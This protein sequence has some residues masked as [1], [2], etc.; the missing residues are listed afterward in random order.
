MNGRDS[1]E[2]KEE[3]E[4]VMSE[5]HLGC[6]PGIFGPHISRFTI[7]LPSGVESS[8][9]NGLFKDQE[10]CTDQ[11]ISFD[12]DGDLVLP[13]RR[14]ISRRCFTMKIQHNITSSIPS[15]GLQVW[16]AELVLSDF[17][18]HK[19]CTSMEFHGI[20]SLE[21]GAGTGLAGMLLA[22]AARTVFL[23]DHGDKI[24]ENCLKNV[25][26]NYGVLKHRNVI[27]V[28]ELDWTHPWPPKDSSDHASQERFTWSSFELEEVQK[29]SLLLAADVIYSDYL[30]DALFGI[31]ERIM[32][33][34]SEKVLYLAL[35]KRYNF[36]LDDL[37]IVA[38]GYSKF[39]SYT[40][41]DS[42]CEG[43]EPGSL[44]CFMGRCIDIAEIPQYVGGYDRGKD[45]ELWEIRYN[46]DTAL[47]PC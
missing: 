15:V 47:M 18:L 40:K 31:L 25:Q 9:F 24:L 46:K 44:P 23:T 35:E 1:K 6:P 4:Q 38:N 39:R 43:L 3:H 19:I 10:P 33:Q 28:R 5:V 8:R 37:D 7:C 32:S 12:E 26:L 34:G 2:D 16:K 14:Q 13:R 42:E 20:V 22:L 29:A 27:Y 21:L 30:T 41:E 17:V 36:S 11:N 45:V